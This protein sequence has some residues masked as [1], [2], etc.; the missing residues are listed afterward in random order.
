MGKRMSEKMSE[1]MAE[2]MR[3]QEGN[4]DVL[5]KHRGDVKTHEVRRRKR[6]Y[7]WAFLNFA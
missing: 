4:G 3:R 6:P 5:V 2:K 7:V 1:K